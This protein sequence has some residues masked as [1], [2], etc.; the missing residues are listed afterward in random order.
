MK[1]PN[2]PPKVR[3]LTALA[4]SAVIF[5]GSG[6][7]SFNRAWRAA[8]RQPVREHSMEGRWEGRWVS[9]V[10]GHN[11]RLLCL[12]TSW[13]DG[14]YA[15]RFRATYLGVLRFSYTVTLAAEQ[16]EGVWHFT[17]EENLGKLAGGVYRYAGQAAPTEFHATY[18]SKYDHGVFQMRRVG[19]DDRAGD[20]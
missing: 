15:A 20:H 2:R 11:G 1:R 13:G 4:V 7:A 10:N 18:H 17:G 14:Q 8:G 6:C 5:F 19:G 12:M 16:R 9:E 3:W